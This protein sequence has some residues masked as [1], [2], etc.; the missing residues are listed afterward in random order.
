L[1][2]V[3]KNLETSSADIHPR[4]SV[5]LRYRLRFTSAF[6]RFV[7]SARHARQASKHTVFDVF[8]L[9]SA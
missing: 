5:V 9:F 6:V 2:C 7:S 8:G 1:F 4:I 3:R